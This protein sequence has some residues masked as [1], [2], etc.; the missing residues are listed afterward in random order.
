MNVCCKVCYSKNIESIE[1]ISFRP[2][3]YKSKWSYYKCNEC[4]TLQ[5]ASI[6]ADMESLYDNGTYES[7]VQGN[8][9]TFKDK[10][11]SKRYVACLKGNKSVI[12][13]MINWLY[14]YGN[15][16]FLREIKKNDYI[17]DVGCG[18]GELLRILYSNGYHNCKG[19]DPFLKED[20]DVDGKFIIEK[21]DIF[22]FL[23]EQKYDVIMLNHV[24]E[25]MEQPRDVL[26]RISTLLKRD[27]R[28]SIE[29]PIINNFLWEK[30]GIYIDSLDP[31]FHFYLY[32][33]ESIKQLLGECGYYIEESYCN[34]SPLLEAFADNAKKED[35]ERRTMLESV[36]LTLRAFRNNQQINRAGNG[37][38]ARFICR[39]IN[40]KEEKE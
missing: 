34:V 3:M 22:S 23:S 10:I 30:Y 16:T 40:Q 2:K 24:F 20:I 4:G 32:T 12:G 8:E 33:K 15:Y 26:N 31:P 35:V 17:L 7:F 18:R 36:R 28:L 5:I 39:L 25:H 29:I 9:Y 1:L 38:I 19:I 11:F 21:T 13:R 6:P 27:G 37:N 14:P